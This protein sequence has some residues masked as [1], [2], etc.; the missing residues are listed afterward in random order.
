MPNLDFFDGSFY[1]LEF[2]CIIKD[3]NGSE[4]CIA[5]H[6][7]RIVVGNACDTPIC[8]NFLEEQ[9]FGIQLEPQ[10]ADVVNYLV[11]GEML[12]EWTKNDTTCFLAK[13]HF[14]IWDDLYLF[15]YCQ[16]QIIRRC[17]PNDQTIRRCLP[18]A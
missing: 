6:L 17:V 12:R 8:E 16:D 13:V 2:D 4:N 9:L 1:C 7:S 11:I 14:F 10:Y 5:D 15:K 3:R 18:N